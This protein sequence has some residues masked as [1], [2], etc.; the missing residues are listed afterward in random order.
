MHIIIP[1]PHPKR[2]II[3]CLNTESLKLSAFNGNQRTIMLQVRPTLDLPLNPLPFIPCK[4]TLVDS[5]RILSLKNL[6]SFI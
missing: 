4:C 1:E 5:H 2:G 6:W 3:I